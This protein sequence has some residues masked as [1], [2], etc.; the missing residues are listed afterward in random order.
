MPN[1]I[2]TDLSE[3]FKKEDSFQ[4][5]YK[6]GCELSALPRE[7]IPSLLALA[8]KIRIRHKENKMFTCSIINAKSGKCTQDCAY[9]SQSSYHDTN[10][11]IYPLKTEAEI[12]ID[13]VM[14]SEAGASRYSMVTSGYMV[15]DK[16]M[17]TICAA[18][19]RIRTE[20]GM[21]VCGSLGMLTKE[22]AA[23]LAE[24][25]MTNY[26]HNLETARS[27]FHKIC[28]T[29]EYD[30]D[31]ETVNLAKDAGLNVCCGGIMGLGETW[32]QRVE[33][34]CTIRELD[35]T[36]VP[37]NFLNPIPGTR[38]EKQPLV[39]PMDALK[40]IAL[41]RI[42]NPEKNIT[43]CG[44]REVTLKDFQSWIF[45]AGANGVMV[46]N[47][48]TTSGRDTRADMEMIGELGLVV[49]NDF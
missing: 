17:D 4:V 45:M 7:D 28:T 29:H 49:T 41:F 36:S 39:K 27:H 43:I 33:L 15:T 23:Q 37:L 38:L 26:H 35:V 8:E 2:I 25:G 40:S 13:A 10:V 6:E 21:E 9:C 48:L 47:Y 44:G 1:Q 14:M 5:S 3:K 12:V 19:E 46:G 30:E 18:T 42:I 16:D 22:R 34:A 20:T 31:I 24:S 11:E 32:D